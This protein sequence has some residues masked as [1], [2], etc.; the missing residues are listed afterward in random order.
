MS[1]TIGRDDS[2]CYVEEGEP[3]NIGGMPT[4]EQAFDSEREAVEYALMCE[5]DAIAPL[6]RSVK[7]LRARM[8]RLAA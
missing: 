3:L 1:G 5:L 2:A 7:R 8:R 6:R 4:G